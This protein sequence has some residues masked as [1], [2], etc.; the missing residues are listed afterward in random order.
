MRSRGCVVAAAVI[1]AL[2]LPIVIAMSKP[3]FAAETTLIWGYT[4]PSSY[5][6]DVYAA[7]D[8]GFMKKHGLDIDEVNTPSVT[9]GEQLLMTSSVDV[10]SANI[11]LTISA[12]DKGADL[13]LIGGEVNRS[14]F[15]LVAQANINSY[16]GLKG[17]TL[18]VTQLN[19]A[20]T[21]MLKL[22]LAKHGIKSGDYDLITSGGTPT[23]FAALKTGA[24]AATMLSQPV[25]FQAQAL[26]MHKLGYAFEAFNGP[27]IAF[28]AQRK[29][30][31]AHSEI[32]VSF[33]QAVDEASRW[34]DDPKNRERA[35]DILIKRTKSAK[36]D[37]QKNYDLWYGPDQIMAVNLALPLDGVQSYLTLHGIKEPP[38]QFVDLSYAKKA[39]R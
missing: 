38:A 39:T 20:S 27:I 21:T 25:D 31:H 15:A 36:D 9:Q 23:R 8:L 33:L 28:A 12:I 17:K 7:I 16:S 1:A 26:G 14:S 4:N 11:E 13:A 3:A 10:L 18:G 2:S 6:W 37:A 30:A 34:L 5:Y 24:I 22:L 35:I 19:E 32:L 29:W